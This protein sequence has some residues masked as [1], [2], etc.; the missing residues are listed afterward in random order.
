VKEKKVGFLLL[1]TVLT[2]LVISSLFVNIEKVWSDLVITTIEVGDTPRAI[3]YNPS[4]ENIYVA[5]LISKSVSVIDSSTNTVI[6]TI[7]IQDHPII[8]EYNP[9]NENIYITLPNSNSVSVIDSS[10]N[11]VIETI[12]VG[13]GPFAIEYNPSNENVYT[14]N[15]GSND[16]SIIDSSTNT[17][18]ET[19]NVGKRPIEIEYNPSNNNIYVVNYASDDISVIS[20]IPQSTDKPIA[21]AGTNQTRE[22]GDLV[23]LDG[24]NSSD[25]N[26]SSLSY[27]WIQTSGPPVALSDPTSQNPTFTAPDTEEQINLNFQL[28][29][30][31]EQG[32]ESQPDSVTITVNPIVSPIADAGINQTVNSGD[33]VQLDGTGSSANGGSPIVEYEWT[34][35]EGPFVTLDDSTSATP[36]FTAPQTEEQE[37]I[38]F[39]L[40]VTNDHGVES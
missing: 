30:T 9:S 10:T 25:P 40:V 14:V 21:D 3:E 33:I 31:N 6:E 8:M 37:N 18:I 35:I 36:S 19:I 22:S 15:V 11:T 32:V 12:E 28:T 2:F 23:Q 13:E 7:S 38:V 17:V 4:N 20:T 26:N 16:S 27:S 24:S 34:Q 29:V 5:N 39:E 1:M